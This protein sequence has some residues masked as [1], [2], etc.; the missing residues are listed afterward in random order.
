[1]QWLK[2]Y[3]AV[4]K[5]THVRLFK[6]VLILENFVKRG[7]MR[8]NKRTRA[9]IRDVPLFEVVRYLEAADSVLQTAKSVV[10]INY[11]RCIIII[12]DGSVRL[13]ALKVTVHLVAL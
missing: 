13:E 1:M 8:L 7:Y 3:H 2:F 5:L 10:R 12:T 6:S 11:F 9:T 4:C